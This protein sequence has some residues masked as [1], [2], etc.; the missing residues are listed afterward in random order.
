MS[1]LNQSEVKLRQK[2][3]RMPGAFGGSLRLYQVVLR[4]NVQLRTFLLD[5]L[6]LDL[7]SERQL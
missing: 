1:S 6:L 4:P 5:L 2:T 3:L 7:F